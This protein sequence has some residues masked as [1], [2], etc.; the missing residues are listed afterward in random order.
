MIDFRK[1]WV[2][3]RILLLLLS[4]L[5]TLQM[6]PALVKADHAG[7]PN[8][9]DIVLTVPTTY[10]LCPSGTDS[11]GVALSNVGTRWLRGYV[12]LDFVIPDGGGRQMVQRWDVLQGGDYR[13]EIIYPA[14]ETWPSGFFEMH[15]DLVFEVYP[16]EADARA[17]TNLLGTIGPGHPWD[18][19]CLAE[20]P[21]ATS[22]P[23]PTP[24]PT[25][26]GMPTPP[27]TP[28]PTPVV[29][30]PTAT[31]G[32]LPTETPITVPPVAPPATPSAD[33]TP[34]LSEPV[35]GELLG[36]TGAEGPSPSIPWIAGLSLG[37]AG[38]LAMRR[39]FGPRH[40][41]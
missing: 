4:L 2:G 15:V 19:F 3:G 5:Y 39:I 14:W 21:P 1:V 34:A 37:I 7:N 31:P 41:G 13:L 11:D 36:R 30:P 35:N 20:R 25:P 32:P 16:T 12:Q 29:A 40:R 27:A 26:T 9:A 33:L 17:G 24:P 22:T 18:I 23:S 6:T 10:M 28:T 38:G 8:I